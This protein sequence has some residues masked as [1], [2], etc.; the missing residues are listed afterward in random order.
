MSYKSGGQ[1]NNKMKLIDMISTYK[2]CVFD[3]DGTTVGANNSV[4]NEVYEL[5]D[6]LKYKLELIVAT[7]RPIVTLKKDE[8]K[9]FYERFNPNIVCYNGNAIYNM[10]TGELKIL[11]YLS[12]KLFKELYQK[13]N[14]IADFIIDDS[15]EVVANSKRAAVKATMFFGLNRS[16]IKITD[17]YTY[18]PR[19]ILSIILSPKKLSQDVLNEVGSINVADAQ[20]EI[21]HQ[22]Q[23]KI[24]PSNSCKGEGV[25]HL[26]TSNG[27][28][29][30]DIVSFGNDDN[31]ISLTKK[32]GIGIAV[33]DSKQSMKKHASIILK[34][35][36]NLNT[37][38]KELEVCETRSV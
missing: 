36:L 34:E 28:S 16:E 25:L 24:I 21:W 19:K 31:D 2:V 17:F 29:L 5:L 4:D 20:L 22:N 35:D 7:G 33:K 10:Q 11:R 23:F 9:S 38:S 1:Y 13:Y 37:L 3:M 32:A 27:F 14:P 26:I 6:V 30:K 12:A 15:G 18:K 8:L